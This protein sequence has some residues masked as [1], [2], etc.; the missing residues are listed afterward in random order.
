MKPANIFESIADDLDKEVFDLIIKSNNVLIERIVSTGQTSDTGWYDQD[1]SEW[2]IVLK[3]KAIIAF[4]NGEEVSLK[5]GD[6]LNIP[7]HSRH[8]VKWTDPSTETIWVAV[9]YR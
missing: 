1:Q 5:P 8:R 6:H 3:G 7:A 2:V 9:H 4:E